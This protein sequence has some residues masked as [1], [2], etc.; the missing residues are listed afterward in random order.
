M[1]RDRRDQELRDF[2][3]LLERRADL[4]GPAKAG[5]LEAWNAEQQRTH[6]RLQRADE[7]KRQRFE[8]WMGFLALVALLLSIVWLAQNG[9]EGLDAALI[10]LTLVVVAKFLGRP[11]TASEATLVRSGVTGVFRDLRQNL[12][13][14]QPAP[15][16]DP[17]PTAGP[18]SP[19][20]P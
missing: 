20:V 3:E 18:A 2:L 7:W 15:A 10:P 16:A 12:A 8:S 19:P 5:V 17:V 1:K 13:P 9:H 6:E 4:K 14:A 11:V